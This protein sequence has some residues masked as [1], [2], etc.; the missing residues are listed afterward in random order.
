MQTEE[1]ATAIQGF[2]ATISK[3]E[4]IVESLKCSSRE[5]TLNI[6]NAIRNDAT[7]DALVEYGKDNASAPFVP[8][9]SHSQVLRSL[10][11]EQKIATLQTRLTEFEDYL[12]DLQASPPETVIEKL[13]MVSQ[14]PRAGS[15]VDLSAGSILDYGKDKDRYQGTQR[16]S[17]SP[18]QT[19]S[20]LVYLYSTDSFKGG[21]Q[22]RYEFSA[23][24]RCRGAQR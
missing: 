9:A 22:G 19:C 8:K 5:V 17:D 7:L 14:L 12:Q 11:Q 23:Q 2:K 6:I 10:S 13:R 21:A 15:N 1:A 3:Y 24:S 20:D 18:V 16:Y 4:A